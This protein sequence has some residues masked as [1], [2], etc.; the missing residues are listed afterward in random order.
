MKEL[1]VFLNH[2]FQILFM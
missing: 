2:R 1:I